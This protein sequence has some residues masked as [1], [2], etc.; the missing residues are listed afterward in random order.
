MQHAVRLALA[1]IFLLIPATALAAP[2]GQES[3]VVTVSPPTARPG[4]T[5]QVTVSGFTAPNHVNTSACVG[6]LGPGQNVELGRT[7]AFRPRVGLVAIGANGT[8]QTSVMVP[9]SFV[10][11][12]YQ[13]VVG[14]CARQPDLA[15]LA[16]LAS[17][18][19]TVV[20]A[21]PTPTR[22][23]ATGGAPGSALAGLFIVGIAA[24]AGGLVSRRA[25]GNTRSEP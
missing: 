18:D 23:P 5:I 1:A 6:M 9:A 12:R 14:G 8:G 15:P 22:L 13:V 4:Q 10:A 17:T 11:G 7:P 19:L 25:R 2:N 21:T 16:A 20:V 24:V 3:P